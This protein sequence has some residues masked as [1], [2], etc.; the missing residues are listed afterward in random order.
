MKKAVFL[1]RDCVLNELVLNPSTREY[2]PP[3]SPED[4]IIFPDVIESLK[5]FQNSGCGLFLGTNQP[6]YTKGKSSL[7]GLHA[8]HAGFHDMLTYEGIN[9]REYFY[10]Y[11]HP[12]GIVPGYSSACNFR[13]PSPY[14]L[15]KAAMDY[16]I[17]LENSWMIGDRDS[18]TE[19]GKSAGTR[20]IMIEDQHS[21]GFWGSSIPD[22][23][24]ANLKEA[25]T[26][27]HH[28]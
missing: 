23:K 6:D 4:L 22:F 8:V 24:T 15:L 11:H 26:I 28:N 17:D 19:C 10:C 1:D 21:S 14:F 12:N 5:I 7:E 25:L 9:L 2:E 20:T 27:I 3:Q 18:D 13:K 16:E